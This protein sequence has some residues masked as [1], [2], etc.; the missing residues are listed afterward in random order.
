MI[1]N[2][3]F[4]LADDDRQQMANITPDAG[5]AWVIVDRITG[6][7]EGSRITE[8]IQTALSNSP[9][10]IAVLSTQLSAENPTMDIDSR[11]FATHCSAAID[12]ASTAKSTY[13][14]PQPSLLLQN[15]TGRLR[16]L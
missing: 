9:Q 10:R 7:M 4:H 6:G 12:D 5:S 2:K 1:E 8:S 14:F 15:F 16:D 13:P 11:S 3:S